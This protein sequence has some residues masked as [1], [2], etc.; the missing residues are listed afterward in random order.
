[1]WL[2][3]PRSGGEIIIM[4]KVVIQCKILPGEVGGVD[5]LRLNFDERKR[6]C[7]ELKE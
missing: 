7:V 6:V 5:S 1:M 2:S 4:V 3:L